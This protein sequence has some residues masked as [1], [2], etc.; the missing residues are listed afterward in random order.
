MTRAHIRI[1]GDTNTY[2]A[3]Q[4]VGKSL[5]AKKKVALKR[6]PSSDA[7]TVYTA[8]PGETVGTVYAWTG[9][10]ASPLW[11]MYYDNKGKTYYTLHEPGV[12]DIKVLKDQGALSVKDQ[13]EKAKEETTGS[14][15]GFKIPDFGLGDTGKMLGKV[16]IGVAV[17]GGALLAYNMSRPKYS[18]VRVRG[19]KR[20]K[21][22]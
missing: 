10:N 5:I 4:I 19:I 2:S 12:Y 17:V 14:G 1:A 11:W 15:G 18:V 22:K 16:L 8:Q 3:D 20:K 9:G 13:T 7:E 21:R 6:F